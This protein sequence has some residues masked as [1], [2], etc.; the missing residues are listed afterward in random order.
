MKP[1]ST[2]RPSQPDERE[3]FVCRDCGHR[4]MV[5]TTLKNIFSLPQKCPKCGSKNVDADPIVVH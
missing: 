1:F 2:V 4:F 5:T 3:L